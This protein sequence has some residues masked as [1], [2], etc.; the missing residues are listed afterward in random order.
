MMGGGGGGFMPPMT[1][2]SKK[3]MS[4]R[5]KSL[6]PAFSQIFQA[7]FKILKT[8]TKRGI[9]PKCEGISDVRD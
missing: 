1:D 8:S 9:M 2:G 4:N 6:T 7:F 5:V 3:P